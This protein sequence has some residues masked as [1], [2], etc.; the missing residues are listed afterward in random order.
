MSTRRH[1]RAGCGNEHQYLER[2]EAQLSLQQRYQM[3]ISRELQAYSKL[4][5]L[6]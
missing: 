6:G 2:A 3:I 5:T 1:G 4:N